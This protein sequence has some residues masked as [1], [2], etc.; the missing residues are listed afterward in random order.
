MAKKKA[1]RVKS[2]GALRGLVALLEERALDNPTKSVIYGEGEAE[3]VVKINP[4]P[5]LEK[6]LSAVQLAAGILFEEENSGAGVDGYVPQLYD[7]ALRYGAVMCYT[8]FTPPADIDLSWN[9][10]L[11]TP[12]FDDIEKIVGDNE[13]Y[14]FTLDFDELVETRKQ[15]LVHSA[16]WRYMARMIGEAFGGLKENL[17][18]IDLT[19]IID[20]VKDAAPEG[21]DIG[22]LLKAYGTETKN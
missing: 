16:G 1:A 14:S 8:D 7:F 17:K 18:D 2:A 13:I 20:S 3:T 12:L 11:Y 22:E 21:F 4:M 19:K 10:L 6:R 9:I 15:A 5:S